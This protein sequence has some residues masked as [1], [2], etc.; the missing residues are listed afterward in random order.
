M[1]ARGKHTLARSD[2]FP[3]MGSLAFQ[4]EHG[5]VC[6]VIGKRNRPGTLICDRYL[7]GTG[8]PVGERPWLQDNGA[9]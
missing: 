4:A 2:Q 9:G 6:L 7:D 1:H 8:D 5:A 3:G